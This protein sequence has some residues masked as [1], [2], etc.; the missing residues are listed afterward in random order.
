MA[1]ILFI[2]TS[3]QHTHVFIA[4]EHE[5]KFEMINKQPNEQ[6]LT[7]NTMIEACLKEALF[8]LKDIQAI[9]VN[10]G[11][12]SYTGLRVGLGVAKGIC[13]SLDI[14]LLLFNKLNILS[15]NYDS[16]FLILK[17]R[18]GEGFAHIKKEGT[19]ILEPVH[20]FYEDFDWHK[21]NDIPMLTD[22]ESLL[23]QFL[24]A[25]VLESHIL[26]AKSWDQLAQQRFD[27]QQFDDIAYSNPY[28]LK[29]AFT[30]TPK[31]KI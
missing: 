15:L 18:K 23:T 22:D 4:S 29:S 20:I 28:Y 19:V 9:A 11:P 7:L 30:T 26:N 8:S 1:L 13:F 21:F 14:P 27:L 12:G 5:L 17:A 3:F 6:A 16:L 2:D 10:G 24:E 31:N 25:K